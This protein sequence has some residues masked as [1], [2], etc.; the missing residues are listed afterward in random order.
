M[1]SNLVNKDF[2]GDIVHVNINALPT[3]SED[4]LA[5]VLRLSPV[6]IAQK[7]TKASA[8]S[9]EKPKES[10]LDYQELAKP[11]NSQQ[12]SEKAGL[13]S[14]ISNRAHEDFKINDSE[15][16]QL[17]DRLS[18]ELAKSD[19]AAP[20]FQDMNAD[21][22]IQFESHLVNEERDKKEELEKKIDE[23]DVMGM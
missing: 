17:L 18:D 14:G 8:M 4:E 16:D 23:S 22:S 9:I 2:L 11:Q 7:I 3:W 12:I 19:V 6:T 13:E 10:T 15:F 1:N 21:S 5:I 20:E